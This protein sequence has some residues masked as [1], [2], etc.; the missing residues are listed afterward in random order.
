MSTPI[1]V[2]HVITGLELGGAERMLSRLCAAFPLE[3]VQ[4]TVVAL[5]SGGPVAAE[6]RASRIPVTELDFG[7]L[8]T[9][10]PIRL[11]KAV[12]AT[13]ANVVHGW[14]YH[15][16]I[17]A[18]IAGAALRTPCLWNI[19]QT[20]Y[21][22]ADEKTLTRQMIRASAVLSSSPRAIV[23]N[24]R[25]SAR[26]HE[27]LGF[28]ARRARLLPNGFDVA[29]YTPRPEAHGSLCEELGLPDNA[30]LLGLFARAHPMKDHAMFCRAASLLV[31][32][33]PSLYCVIGGAGT[34][35]AELAEVVTKAGLN[36]RV[37]LLGARDDMPRLTAAV[38]IACSASAWGEGF[39]NVLAEAMACEVP[40]VFTDIGDACDVVGEAGI[41]VQSGDAEAFASACA[42]LLDAPNERRRLGRIGRERVLQHY[43]LSSV[44]LAYTRL[45][46]AVVSS[47]DLSLAVAT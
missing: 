3:R 37:V 25:L 19:R 16:N 20:V 43:S 24:S 5:R 1:R 15:G 41:V 34:R 6:L 33:F 23:Y 28:N 2:C 13:R 36:G 42:R 46:E 32:R 47:P 45:Y 40:C 26:Q 35:S 22:L 18:T 44:V 4:S 10:N 7:S 12:R 31:E 11:V 8:R 39:P 27:R 14:M 9:T 17:A 38:D 30:L 21:D 29:A